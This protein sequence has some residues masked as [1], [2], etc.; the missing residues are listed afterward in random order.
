MY[1]WVVALANYLTGAGGI[2]GEWWPAE[3]HIVGKDVVRFHA[4]Y[5]G[6]RF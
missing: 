2:D 4:I 5:N 3:L 6:R 1:V